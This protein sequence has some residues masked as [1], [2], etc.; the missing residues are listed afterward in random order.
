[1]GDDRKF[2][3]LGL[4]MS[5]TIE[6][7]NTSLADVEEK[8]RQEFPSQQ[9]A[10]IIRMAKLI[11]GKCQNYGT[12]AAGI[13]ISDNGDVSDHLPLIKVTDAMDCQ[14]DLNYVEPL[15]MLKL[16]LLG[17]RNLG[18]ITE[19]EK[20]IQA[21]TGESISIDQLPPDDPEVMKNIFAAGKTN[22]VFQFESE[23]MKKVLTGFGPESISDLTLLNAL[24]RPGPLQYI[25]DVTQVKKGL[26]TPEYVIPEMAEILGQTYGKPV[27]QEQIIQIFNRFAGFSLGEAD[28][29][30][31]YMSK[32]KYDK[33]ASYKDKFIDGLVAHGAD[34]K[35]AEKFWDE[36]L[37]FS[38]YAFNKSH[39]RAYSEVAYATAYLKYY[40]PAAY[41]VG[42]LNYTA[43]DKREDVLLEAKNNGI[44]I[45]V[46]DINI[47][48][49]NFI[50][51]GDKVVYGLNSITQV[52]ASASII[53]KEREKNGSFT[54]FE[55]FIR[56]CRLRKNVMENLI[57][58]GSFDRFCKNRDAL[59]IAYDEKSKAIETL[60]KKQERLKVEP[61]EARR[62]KLE[63]T[64]SEQLSIINAP[65]PKCGEDRTKRLLNERD[66]LGYFI[67]GHP[68][69]QKTGKN[70]V[71]DIL[72]TGGETVV[73]IN[74]V[75]VKTSKAG[76]KYATVVCEDETGSIRCTVFQKDLDK[77]TDLL[78]ENSVVTLSLIKKDGFI[79]NK[80]FT[81]SN[82]CLYLTVSSYEAFKKEAFRLSAFKGNK[83]LI[84]FCKDTGRYIPT[85]YFVNSGLKTSE[86]F[87]KI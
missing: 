82:E 27:Y 31:R 86:R 16:D 7:L 62:T 54:S 43:S 41:T 45:Q 50:L 56:R 19:C 66:V 48:R 81:F 77:Y 49:E 38:A 61:S 15:G 39:A 25:D 5:K 29:I 22:G 3:G 60:E 75:E 17:L 36:L 83:K 71:Q 85:V 59:L 14:C 65:Y 9:A 53:V 58:A 8:L 80:V 63:Q 24:F 1:M 35:A 70:K 52:A 28:V 64:I 74:S 72:E 68:V 44:E 46:P 73:F 55:D 78:K 57:K 30:R 2:L 87:N 18:I 40:Y 51:N 34:S 10:E 69:P 21:N 84:L 37:D 13:I 79:I 67:S 42:L 4:D 11:E 20:A 76:N 32:K 6:E 47:A 26:K 33:F 12:H 23:G